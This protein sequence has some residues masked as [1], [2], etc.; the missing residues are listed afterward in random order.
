[1]KI[2][3]KYKIDNQE[4]VIANDNNI[5]YIIEYTIK[6]LGNN[7][8]LNFIDVSKVNN[9]SG[10]F[11]SSEFNG[12]ISK[13]DVSNVKYMNLLFYK[14]KFNRDI[15]NW[16]V[17]NIKDMDYKFKDSIFNKDIS[18]WDVSNVSYN[19]DIFYNCRNL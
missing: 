9:M 11:E 13:W 17:S 3:F 8:D 19:K 6:K 16:D 15:S 2:D 18:S 7:A 14:S 1:M 12:D 10:I 5:E 4:T